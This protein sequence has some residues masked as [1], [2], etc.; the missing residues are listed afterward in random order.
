MTIELSKSQEQKLDAL[1]AS[2]KFSSKEV[3]LERALE[4]LVQMLKEEE[5]DDLKG[6]KA[7]LQSMLIGLED[8]VR[9]D[10]PTRP[11]EL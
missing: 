3:A 5:G 2:G 11:V 6:F 8:V 1:L 7:F 10:T 4:T 9:D